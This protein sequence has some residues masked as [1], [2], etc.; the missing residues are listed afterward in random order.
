MR[1]H[2]DDPDRESWVELME[3]K[4]GEKIEDVDIFRNFMVI[5]AKRDA[6]PVVSCYHFE[7]GAVHEVPLPEQFC[8]IGAGVNLVRLHPR[9]SLVKNCPALFTLTMLTFQLLGLRHRLFPVHVELALCTRSHVRVRYGLAG[10]DS[11]SRP[12]YPS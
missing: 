10:D 7:T 5:Y 3:A 4:D 2:R 12:S 1:A 11:A 9:R 6:L 8:T